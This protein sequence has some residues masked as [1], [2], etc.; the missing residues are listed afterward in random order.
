MGLSKVLV[1]EQCVDKAKGDNGNQRCQGKYSNE[2]VK[3]VKWSVILMVEKGIELIR[4]VVVC[5][6]G[7]ED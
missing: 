7:I 5:V 2:R 6:S 1:H 3:F 4:Y